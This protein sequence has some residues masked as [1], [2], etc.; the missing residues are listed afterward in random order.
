M[1]ERFKNAME[2]GRPLCRQ[3]RSDSSVSIQLPEEVRCVVDVPFLGGTVAI[4]STEE[5]AFTE[6][7]IEVLEIFSKVISQAYRRLEDLRALAAAEERIRQV[8]RLE[9]IGQLAGGVAHDF[10][11]LLTIIS[12]YSQL[13]LRSL[14]SSD[15]LYAEIEG[16]DK[17]T[18]RG[19]TLVRQL[20]A[21]SRQQVLNPTELNLNTFVKDLEKMLRRLLRE[22]IELTL[23]LAPALGSVR[24][25]EGQLQQVLLNLVVN[26]RD[27]MPEG[28]RLIIE[29]SD[30]EWD[31]DHVREGVTIKAGP[32]V[33]LAVCDTGIGMSAETRAHA[34]EPFFT[35]KEPGKG[36]GLG[37]SSVYGIVKQSGGYVWISS[38]LG[39]G[40]TFEIYLPR[41]SVVPSVTLRHAGTP[42]SSV[43]GVETVLLV[44]D[45]VHLRPVVRQMLEWH[46]YTVLEATDGKAALRLAA[47]HEAPIHL[48][49]TDVVMP[50]MNGRELTGKLT[51]LHPEMKVLYM[52]GYAEGVIDQRGVLESGTAF[53]QKPF[54]LDTLTQ[55]VR[56]ILDN[57][58]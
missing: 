47:E 37:L 20:L 27:A 28:G 24:V 43:R 2:N 49:L 4:N 35:T 7:D 3:R 21:F 45:D 29:T 10:N 46:D 14:G 33:R 40:T 57:S 56:Q 23:K 48:L 19:S 17:A 38:E 52:S 41:T 32:Y 36:T 6:R 25:D 30:V 54:T 51:A 44:E 31:E 1:L 11:N 8:Q 22:D 39:R 58:P 26:A 9:A 55:K 5:D 53:I 15:P 50:E 42:R 12:G 18:Q 34:F 16:I 13:L